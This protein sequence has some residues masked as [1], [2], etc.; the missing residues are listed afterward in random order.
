MTKQ[1]WKELY[2]AARLL[3]DARFRS[4][5]NSKGFNPDAPSRRIVWDITYDV[6][7]NMG[8]GII[9]ACF[10][11]D[12]QTYPIKEHPCAIKTNSKVFNRKMPIRVS[13]RKWRE[14]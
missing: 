2:S 5:S 12:P 9:E 6:I 14:K 1:E 8:F 10:N 13:K 4:G 3:R 11:Y 7:K